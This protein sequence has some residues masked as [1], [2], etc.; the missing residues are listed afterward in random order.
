MDST[1]HSTC[2]YFGKR[3]E[4]QYYNCSLMHKC[5]FFN[6]KENPDD[7]PPIERPLPGYPSD[8]LFSGCHIEAFVEYSRVLDF[9]RKITHPNAIKTNFLELDFLKSLVVREF[10]NEIAVYYELNRKK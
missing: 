1:G 5:N 10:D 9:Y 8:Y 6:K 7:E 4:S 3:D 2:P